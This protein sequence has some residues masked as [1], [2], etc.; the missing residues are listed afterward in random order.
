[1][2]YFMFPQNR[3]RRIFAIHLMFGI[4]GFVDA[5]FIH[6]DAQGGLAY[7]VVPL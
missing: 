2:V 5:I 3:E 1:M 7:I 4:W 6:P